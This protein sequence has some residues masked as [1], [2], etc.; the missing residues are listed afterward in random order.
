[1]YRIDFRLPGTTETCFK[2]KETNKN[3]KKRKGKKIILHCQMI[4]KP[5]PIQHIWQQMEKYIATNIF[6]NI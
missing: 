1:M 2:N 6:L 4:A 5:S 3:K